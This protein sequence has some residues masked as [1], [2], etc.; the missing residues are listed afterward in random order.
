MFE[1]LQARFDPPFAGFGRNRSEINQNGPKPTRSGRC[2]SDLGHPRPTFGRIRP[3]SGTLDRVRGWI[4][5]PRLGPLLLGRIRS[6]FD[7]GGGK[8]GKATSDAAGPNVFVPLSWSILFCLL[9]M[10]DGIVTPVVSVLG[11]H[12]LHLRRA[13]IA[14]P[15][16]LWA[17][18][19]A[20]ST[21]RC[22]GMRG[23][24]E[25]RMVGAPELEGGAGERRS[26]GGRQLAHR[27]NTAMMLSTQAV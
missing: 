27:P 21:E 15:P 17:W 14:G 24:S 26:G 23:G 6:L 19:R 4:T 3:T 9:P 7:C 20:P 2:R 13:A 11:V 25:G 1:Q 12:R 8:K 5:A 10:P 22:V 16:H 18:F